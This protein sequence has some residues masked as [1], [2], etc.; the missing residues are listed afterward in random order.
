MVTP[1][2]DFSTMRCTRNEE[3]FQR[4]PDTKPIH[5]KLLSITQVQQ[6]QNDHTLTCP[7]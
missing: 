4:V 2:T 5:N 3:Y 6:I 1:T 7:I